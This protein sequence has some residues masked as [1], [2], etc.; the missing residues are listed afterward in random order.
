MIPKSNSKKKSNAYITANLLM[1]GTL[2]LR[3]YYDYTA[4]KSQL[5]EAFPDCHI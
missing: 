4:G 1:M 3:K 5:R 2:M